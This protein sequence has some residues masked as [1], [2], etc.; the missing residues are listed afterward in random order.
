VGRPV[1][2]GPVPD[3]PGGELVEEVL[4]GGRARP[5]ISSG[6]FF[7][8]DPLSHPED[9]RPYLA[10]L[11]HWKDGHSAAAIAR[12]WI[13]TGDIPATV[14]SVL[15]ASEVFRDATLVEA[16]FEHQTALRTPGRKSQ[17]DVLALV[18]V[19]EGYAVLA[20]EGKCHESFGEKVADW[21]KGKIK[22]SGATVLP[23]LAK[24]GD[25]PTRRERLKELCSVLGLGPAKSDELRYQLLHR[26]VAGVYEAK[27]YRCTHAVVIVHS[28]TGEACAGFN[29]FAAFS[30]ALGIPVTGAV[31][32]SAEKDMDGVAVRLAWVKDG[33]V[34]GT[35]LDDDSLPFLKRLR[36]SGVLDEDDWSSITTWM[37]DARAYL[38]RPD[39]TVSTDKDGSLILNMDA[40]S[41]NADWLRI[42]RVRR[43]TGQPVPGWAALWL[44]RLGHDRRSRFWSRVAEVARLGL[45]GAVPP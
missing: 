9:V 24:A 12:S 29:D 27:R 10:R 37:S 38:A 22:V 17:T 16:F 7:H 14:R 28:F 11:S 15:S 6:R 26:T 2:S 43:L 40:D 19:R 3:W 1:F 36:A 25:S 44:W 31:P 20:V 8:A 42:V 4:N 39:Q 18:A 45:K 32:L 30:R 21:L 41:R 5:D 23:D 34:P 35:D 33:V 13:G